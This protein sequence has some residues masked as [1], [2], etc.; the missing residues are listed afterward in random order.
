[1]STI[2]LEKRT[3]DKLRNLGRKDQTYDDI[4]NELIQTREATKEWSNGIEESTE[5]DNVK[6]K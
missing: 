1:M 2:F 3:R 4:I 5:Q 6:V